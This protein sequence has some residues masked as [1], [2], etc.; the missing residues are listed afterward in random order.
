MNARTVDQREFGSRFVEGQLLRI[1]NQVLNFL[2]SPREIIWGEGQM[3][4]LRQEGGQQLLLRQQTFSRSIDQMDYG[5][6]MS[7]PQ[8]AMCT[9]SAKTLALLTMAPEDGGRSGIC[10]A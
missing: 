3:Y 7:R 2:V 8:S 1:T 5:S 9:L 10:Y 6:C 4:T